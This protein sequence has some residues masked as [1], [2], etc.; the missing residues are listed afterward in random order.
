M[1]IVDGLE[2]VDVDDRK[3]ER[4]N[5]ALCALHLLIDEPFDVL[6]IEYTRQAV[7]NGELANGSQT[8]EVRCNTRHELVRHEGLFD[9]VI[10]PDGETAYFLRR[11]VLCSDEQDRNER[12]RRVAAKNLAERKA[13]ELGHGHVEQNQVR[14]RARK[15]LGSHTRVADHRGLI[16]SRLEA[17]GDDLSAGQVVID[18]RDGRRAARFEDRRRDHPARRRKQHGLRGRRLVVEISEAVV[19]RASANAHDLEELVLLFWRVRPFRQVGDAI[20]HRRQSS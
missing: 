5:V 11:V 4:C 6:V 17:G 20:T 16:T 10:P 15:A 19:R 18:D 1:G 9:V 13:I 8:F 7:A 2:V 12:E 14:Q 3:R